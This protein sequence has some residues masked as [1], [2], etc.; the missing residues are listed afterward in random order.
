MQQSAERDRLHDEDHSA[1]LV[2]ARSENGQT[3]RHSGNGDGPSV[4]EAVVG[5]IERNPVLAAGAALTVGAAVAMAVHSRRTS[6]NRIDKRIE[7]AARSMDRAFSREM[8]ALRR[9]DV[10]DRLGQF[11]SSLGD[12]FSR[13]DLAPLAERGRHYL[14]VARRRIGA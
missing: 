14:D 3:G 13:V 1:T 4:S 10:A 6:N 11:G 9:S 2:P 12:A 8:K 7:R 5:F